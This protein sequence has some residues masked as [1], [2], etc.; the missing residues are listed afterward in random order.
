MI[1]LNTPV[2]E[3]IYRYFLSF[4]IEHFILIIFD[5]L[6][7][8]KEVNSKIFILVLVSFSY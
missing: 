1:L 8:N 7:K 3:M 5:F 2:H 4:K 6:E